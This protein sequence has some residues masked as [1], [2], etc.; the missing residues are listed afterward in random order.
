[1]IEVLE[2]RALLADGI[3]PAAGAPIGAVAGVPIT[4]AVFATSTVSDPSAL[5][6]PVRADAGADPPPGQWPVRGRR[7]APILQAGAFQ[8]TVTIRDAAGAEIA[9]HGLVNVRR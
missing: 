4:N 6:R 3:A 7:L 1:M 2:T 5:L 8:V 9:A